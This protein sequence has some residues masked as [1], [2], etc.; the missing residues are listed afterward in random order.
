MRCEARIIL[1]TVPEAVAI[2]VQ[3]VFNEGPVQFVYTPVGPRFERVPVRIGRRSDTLAEVVKGLDEGTVV[4]LREPASGEVLAGNFKPEML[5]AAGYRLD[6]SGKV[7]AEGG[8][9]PGGPAAGAGVRPT[10]GPPADRGRRDGRGAEAPASG[11]SPT[12][13]PSPAAASV[14]AEGKPAAQTTPAAP[15]AGR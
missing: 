12:P 2:P 13:A 3:A 5:T 1:D 15:S 8:M 9:R 6:D 14:P 4:L 11:T 10:G 7:I